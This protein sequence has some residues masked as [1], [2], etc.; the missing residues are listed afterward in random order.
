MVKGRGRTYSHAPSDTAGSDPLLQQIVKVQAFKDGSGH[1]LLRLFAAPDGFRKQ[2][3][4]ALRSVKASIEAGQ[5]TATFDNLALGDYAIAVAHDAND[6][7]ELDFGLLGITKEGYG[8]SRDA[9]TTM[10]PADF[11]QAKIRLQSAQHHEVVHMR[12]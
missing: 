9:K 11:E 2:A 6:S 4:K 7:G 8:F 1:A 5:A 12:Y 3:A 10:G